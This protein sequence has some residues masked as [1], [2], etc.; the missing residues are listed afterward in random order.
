[1]SIAYRL[2]T[3]NGPDD[4]QSEQSEIASATSEEPY[5]FIFGANSVIRGLEIAVNYLGVGGSGKVL[6]RSDLAYGKV[7]QPPDIMGD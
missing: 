3:K 2:Y 1:M 7:G 5:K 6:I 4:G